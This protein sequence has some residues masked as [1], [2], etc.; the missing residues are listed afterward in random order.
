MAGYSPVRAPWRFPVRVSRS[1]TSPPSC[2]T[3]WCPPS[4]LPASRRVGL[5]A[6]DPESGRLEAQ[7]NS[8]PWPIAKLIRGS[9]NRVG[10]NLEPV[11]QIPAQQP[12]QGPDFSRKQVFQEV[13]FPGGAPDLATAHMMSGQLRQHG[14]AV[15]AIQPK[16][17]A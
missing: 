4:G 10:L 6:N 16:E 17:I 2:V 7:R 1:K 3:K 9:L 12:G 14:L 13:E 8:P 5:R 15:D 11:G